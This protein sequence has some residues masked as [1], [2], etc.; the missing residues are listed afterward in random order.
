MASEGKK[1]YGEEEQVEQSPRASI[2]TAE[3]YLNLLLRNVLRLWLVSIYLLCR[4][5]GG[6]TRLLTMILLSL[7]AATA[8]AGAGF[9]PAPR[10]GLV[11]FWIPPTG[12]AVLG[13][14][15]ERRG[16]LR[17]RALRR[18]AEVMSSR[19]WSSFPDIVMVLKDGLMRVE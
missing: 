7:L 8:L 2:A 6:H 3:T 4:I 5:V 1:E 12:A 10:A 11:F 17:R 9:T 15:V 14:P 19:A 18:W 13:R 16:A